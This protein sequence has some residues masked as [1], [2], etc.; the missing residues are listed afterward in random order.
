S[1]RSRDRRRSRTVWAVW[2]PPGR[3]RSVEVKPPGML[4]IERRVGAGAV[5]DGGYRP[6]APPARSKREGPRRGEA[7]VCRSAFLAHRRQG[8]QLRQHPDHVEL[9]PMLGHAVAFETKDVDGFHLERL[10]G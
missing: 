5:L 8:A 3:G 1:P 10:A 6:A 2:T 7:L 9:A 4:R